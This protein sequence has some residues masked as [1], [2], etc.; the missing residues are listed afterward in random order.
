[1]RTTFI[2]VLIEHAKKDKSIFLLTPDMGF[3]VFEPFIEKFPDQFLNTG[4]SEQNT[5]SVAAGLALSGLK[6]YIYSIAPFALM[7]C[8]EQVRIDVAYM[9]TNIKII[10]AG[11]G[12]AYGPAGATHHCIE[13]FA[14][15]KVL[16]NMTVCS[17]ADPVEAKCIF[18][19][20][21]D[22]KSPMWI[23]IAKNK[24]PVFHNQ[25]DKIIIGKA[26]EFS[27]GQ[28]IQILSTGT[29]A[30]KIRSWVDIF[31]EQG[32]DAGITT[33]PTIKPLDTEYLDSLIATKQKIIVV[34]EHNIIGGL[35]ESISSYL[36][37]KNSSNQIKLIGFPDCYS[38][39]IGDQD[40][41]LNKFGI[42][43]VPIIEELFP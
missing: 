16:P 39:F 14:I 8:Y 9:N 25:D 24:D 13:D 26:F 3:S 12:V 27:R 36:K 7:R 21:I 35:G 40:Y 34:E 4:I 20:S 15:T 18:E 19:Q 41:I 30:Y 5:I 11:S 10:G 22:Y 23:R 1:M 37:I 29:I 31:K 43:Q 17:P 33:F 2:N 32:F 42:L 6:P 38:H 28:D